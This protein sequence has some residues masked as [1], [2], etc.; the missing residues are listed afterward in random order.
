M[1][2]IGLAVALA[3]YGWR[4]F[5]SW[6]SGVPVHWVA[7]RGEPVMLTLNDGT[8][9]RLD[10]DSDLVV[11]FGVHARR[12]A[13]AHGEALF[14]VAYDPL[15]P[16][17]VD[18]GRGRVIDLGTRFDVEK[19]SDSARVTVLEGRVGLMTPRGEVV[20]TAGHSGGYEASGGL[21]QVSTV[22]TSIPLWQDGQRHFDNEPLSVIAERLGRYHSVDF[23]FAEPELRRLRISGTF[24]TDDLDLF[25]RTLSAAFPVKTR[26]LDPQHLQFVSLVDGGL[27]E[28]R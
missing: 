9:V 19:L 28:Q 3:I 17:E 22:D 26:W 1:G 14:T 5:D 4:Y 21:L 6:W 2:A 25:L 11:K 23:T 10:A 7:R 20:L 18:I 8:E 13:L 16:F 15:R 12:A 24:R 27:E